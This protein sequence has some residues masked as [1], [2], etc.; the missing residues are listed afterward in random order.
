[1]VMILMNVDVSQF[2][3]ISSYLSNTHAQEEVAGAKW[4]LERAREGQLFANLHK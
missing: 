1:M 3:E 4:I 2:P